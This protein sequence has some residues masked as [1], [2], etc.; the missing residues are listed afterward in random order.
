[1]C[2]RRCGT[3]LGYDADNEWCTYRHL[4][5]C[6]DET[7][8]ELVNIGC[9]I[10]KGDEDYWN[11][12]DLKFV[13]EYARK[14]ISNMK[15]DPTFLKV[16]KERLKHIKNYLICINIIRGGDVGKLDWWTIDSLLDEQM[17]V[18]GKDRERARELAEHIQPM[19]TKW[20]KDEKTRYGYRC[21][22]EDKNVV[23]IIEDIFKNY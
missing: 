11:K 12:R 6:A 7:D 23:N 22:T 1:M 19:L 14:S 20:Y 4:Y 16:D 15:K 10:E 9:Y 18:S 5:T 8:P 21:T 13:Q 3:C 17:N 2:D